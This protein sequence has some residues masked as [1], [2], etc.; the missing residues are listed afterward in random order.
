[1]IPIRR[2]SS[3]RFGSEEIRA[4]L[5]PWNL[6]RATSP[7]ATPPPHPQTIGTGTSSSPIMTRQQLYAAFQLAQ[8]ETYR[9]EKAAQCRKEYFVPTG[10]GITCLSFSF[11]RFAN[12]PIVLGA[13]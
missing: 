10:K 7:N 6:A 13:S 8:A 4:T 1:M 12:S 9:R 11:T 2:S 3:R 5:H